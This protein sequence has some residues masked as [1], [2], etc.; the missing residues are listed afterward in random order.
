LDSS[1]PIARII[2]DTEGVYWVIIPIQP[3]FRDLAVIRII[4]VN[5]DPSIVIHPPNQIAH[6]FLYYVS[7]EIV[8]KPM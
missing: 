7:T 2:A 6:S 1:D 4:A 8:D 5:N 3:M